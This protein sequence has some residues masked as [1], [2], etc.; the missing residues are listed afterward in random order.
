MG[1]LEFMFFVPILQSAKFIG[2]CHPAWLVFQTFTHSL[3]LV[4]ARPPLLLRNRTMPLT[5]PVDVGPDLGFP[6]GH[7]NAV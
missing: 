5:V 1:W 4:E 2:V 7:W 6:Y 3:D